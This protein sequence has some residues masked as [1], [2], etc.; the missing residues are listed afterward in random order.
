MIN[1]GEQEAYILVDRFIETGMPFAMYRIPGEKVIHLMVQLNSEVSLFNDIEEL[2]G[3]SG[4]VIAPFRIGK[5]TPI[6]LLRPDEVCEIEFDSTKECS[7]DIKPDYYSPVAERAN[8][9]VVLA[10]SSRH[11]VKSSSISW[12]FPVIRNWTFHRNF[13]RQQLFMRLVGGICIPMSI[14]AIL[15]KPGYG[16][17]VLRKLF[18]QEKKMNGAR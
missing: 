1:T 8:M 10:F 12:Y 18:L 2:N 9:P 15:H 14:Y 13:H 4:F 5:D 7:D 17:V 11:C 3:R 6:V 16:W